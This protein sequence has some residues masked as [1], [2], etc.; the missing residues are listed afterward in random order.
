MA[1]LSLVWVV[2][3]NIK[4]SE[5]GDAPDCADIQR[6]PA[7]VQRAGVSIGHSEI[8]HQATATGR[9]ARSKW[10]RWRSGSMAT[11]AP[12]K[13]RVSPWLP[14]LPSFS[15]TGFDRGYVPNGVAA[16]ESHACRRR[17]C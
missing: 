10:C 17:F 14:P 9:S 7:N 15:V 8:W 4:R 6:C 3:A 1:S 13:T 2:G 11:V 16:G 5:L 12:G